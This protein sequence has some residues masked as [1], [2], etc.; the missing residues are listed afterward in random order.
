MKALGISSGWKLAAPIGLAGQR[1]LEPED[2]M[3]RVATEGRAMQLDMR[4]LE[5]RWE[6]VARDPHCLTCGQR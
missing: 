4:T 2:V 1:V 6:S 5:Q 3:Q